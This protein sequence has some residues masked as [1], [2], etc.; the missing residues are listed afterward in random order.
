[1]NDDEKKELLDEIKKIGVDW[2]KMIDKLVE[3]TEKSTEAITEV[4]SDLKHYAPTPSFQRPEF[5]LQVLFY[6]VVV[7]LVVVAISHG[8]CI[9]YED[10]KY[11][12]PVA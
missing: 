2:N 5:W 1:M 6:V 11:D 7:I 3:L 10:L 9:Q 12:C 4:K 8:G